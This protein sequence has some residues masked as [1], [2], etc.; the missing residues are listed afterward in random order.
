MSDFEFEAR[1]ERLF[2]K[3]PVV[4]DSGAFTARVQSRLE[5]GWGLRQVLIGAAGVVGGTVAATQAFGSGLLQQ[6][7]SVRLPSQPLLAEMDP[8]RLISGEVFAGGGGEVVWMVV[9][10]ATLTVAFAATRFADTF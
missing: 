10:M 6:L 5:R 2:A 9:A 8:A 7:E 4:T 3:P 1:L